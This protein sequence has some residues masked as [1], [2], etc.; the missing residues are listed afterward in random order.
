M[1]LLKIVC[2]VE[3]R[4]EGEQKPR[5]PWAV[6]LVG[7]R[8]EAMSVDNSLYD[9]LEGKERTRRTWTHDAQEF[10]FSFA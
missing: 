2:K 3:M 4:E 9:S 10:F 1:T 8:M 7:G 6:E 5:L